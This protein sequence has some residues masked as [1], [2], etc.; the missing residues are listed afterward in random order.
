MWERWNAVKNELAN[1]LPAMP[2][3]TEEIEINLTSSNGNIGLPLRIGP[4]GMSVCKV[5][6]YYMNDGSFLDPATELTPEQKE[7]CVGVVCFLSD[8]EQQQKGINGYAMALH[9]ANGKPC[10]WGDVS[11]FKSRRPVGRSGYENTQ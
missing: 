10:N 4:N 2:A 5:G 11:I 3:L 1:N 9:D 7:N 6:S 8:S